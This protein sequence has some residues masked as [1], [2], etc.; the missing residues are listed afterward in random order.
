MQSDRHYAVLSKLA[1]YVRSPSLRHIRDPRNLQ[2]L[3]EELVRA[4]DSS[5]AVWTK[6][7]SKRE[8]LA[9]AAA[10]CWVPI[11][12]LKDFLNDLQGP[13][14]TRTDVTERLRAICEEPWTE[15]PKDELEA[16]CLALYESEKSQGTEMPAIIGA[17]RAHIENEEERLRKE[18]EQAHQRFKEEDRLKRERRFLSGADCGWT[19]LDKAEV[20]YCR[21][22][23]RAFRVARTKDQHWNLYRI[24]DQ[25]DEGELLGTYQGRG[26]ASNAI[27]Q[28]A[29]APEVRR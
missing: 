3:T 25:L 13:P 24:K 10:P 11:D 12:D 22:N 5:N 17:L 2:K 16:G 21:R 14:L 6:W 29:Y 26:D 20:F 19:Q 4:I 27:K 18:R 15:Y 28:L 9:K 8:D 23:G 7:N 1:D